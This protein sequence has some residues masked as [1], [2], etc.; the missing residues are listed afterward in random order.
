MS[1]VRLDDR[2]PDHPKVVGLS[3]AALALWTRARCWVNA[4]NTSGMV[5][6]SALWRL[7][8]SKRPRQ[9]VAELVEAGLWEAVDGD[10]WRFHDYADYEPTRPQAP[11]PTR[12]HD[13]APAISPDDELR[14]KR[15]EAGRAGA[16]R[17]WGSLAADG[18]LPSAHDGKPMA[19]AISADG[20]LPSALEKTDSKLPSSRIPDQVS[21][22]GKIECADGVNAMRTPAI[23]GFSDGK[24]PWPPAPRSPSARNASPEDLLAWVAQQPCLGAL[25]ANRADAIE[26]AEDVAGSLAMAGARGEDVHSAIAEYVTANATTARRMSRHE[27]VKGL[28]AY[29]NRAKAHGDAARARGAGG[30][31]GRAGRAAAPAAPAGGRPIVQAAEPEVTEEDLAEVRRLLQPTAEGASA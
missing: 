28:G 2:F 18:T 21:L 7:S 8:R 23:G 6:A 26:W 22:D 9:A 29:L 30:P 4:Q 27:L 3:D 24:E 25:V 12:A 11:A 5:P 15:S 13:P 1:W 10:A 19:L 14:R 17:R 16:Q 20:T 31:G